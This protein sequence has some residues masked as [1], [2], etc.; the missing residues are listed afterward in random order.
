MNLQDGPRP[1]VAADS[2]PAAHAGPKV[3]ELDDDTILAR[4][5]E[6]TAI[7]HV[8]GLEAQVTRLEND[9]RTAQSRIQRLRDRLQDRNAE[10]AAIRASRTWRA[11]R[12]I[13]G[14]L[15]RLRG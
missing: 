5:A 1:G 3:V 7:D 2:T 10:L 4:H 12:V 6:L 13:T 14:P 8:L 9:L 15:G 11:G